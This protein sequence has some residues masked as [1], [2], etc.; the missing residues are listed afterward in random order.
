MKK[1]LFGMLQKTKKK[2]SHLLKKAQGKGKGG[3]SKGEEASSQQRQQQGGALDERTTEETEAPGAAA[4]A[5]AASTSGS[6][7]DEEWV[8]C[9]EE[10]AEGEAKVD[11]RLE[12]LLTGVGPLVREQFLNSIS[13]SEYTRKHKLMAIVGTFNVN[14]KTPEEDTRV[15]RWLLSE[16][17]VDIYVAGFQEIVPLTAS[18][19]LADNFAM[20]PALLQWET[21]LDRTL[22][23]V[24]AEESEKMFL[25]GS[26]DY[27]SFG[28][29]RQYVP[30]VA[31]SMV[32]IYLTVWVKTSLL[33][34]I[35]YKEVVSVSCGVMRVLGNKG[36]VGV[37]LRIYDTYLSFICVH[38]SSGESESD[39]ARRYWDL[40]HIFQKST[41]M[42]SSANDHDQSAM[43][44]YNILD[45]DY[46]FLFGDLNFRLNHEE[47]YIR[48]MIKSGNYMGLLD[49]DQLNQGRQ[50]NELLPGWQEG[51]ITFPPTFKYTIGTDAYVGSETNDNNSNNKHSSNGSG[52]E[53]KVQKKR[54]PAW[55]DRILWK[56]IKSVKLFGYSDVAEIRLSDH[57]PVFCGFMIHLHE[58]LEQ[59][60]EEAILSA[61]RLADLK[62]ME[63]RP[64]LELPNQFFDFGAITYDKKVTKVVTIENEGPVDAHWHLSTTGDKPD[65]L[66]VYPV[67]GKVAR[68]TSSEIKLVIHVEGGI[69]GSAGQL[70]SREID[71]ILVMTVAG[72]GDKFISITGKYQFSCFGVSPDRLSEQNPATPERLEK[73]KREYAAGARGEEEEEESAV[74][75]QDSEDTQEQQEH[76]EERVSLQLQLLSLEE[77]VKCILNVRK[78]DTAKRWFDFVPIVPLELQNLIYFI[79]NN[80]GLKKANLIISPSYPSPETIELTRG[81]MDS[82]TAIPSTKVTPVDAS[83][84][85]L[86][87]LTSF[88]EPLLPK[89][90][91]DVCSLCVP[92]GLASLDLL[93]NNMEK[94][95]YA[96]FLYLMK[97]F[98]EVLKEENSQHNG[99]TVEV[100]A[101]TLASVFL[102]YEIQAG[103]PLSAEGT[104]GYNDVI[105]RRADFLKTFLVQN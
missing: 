61:R 11:V 102:T 27:A 103:G 85:L 32:G 24:S 4:A 84:V 42:S 23:G 77:R 105:K 1:Q 39:C 31:K 33:P 28:T 48:G 15:E 104:L 45:S 67:Q 26:V 35:T 55:C 17:K 68:G 6:S 25:N 2:T 72:A 29:K 76:T 82:D 43:E 73:I 47:D 9:A 86:M 75:T 87:Y 13:S 50:R 78:E 69:S 30:L 89:Q 62:E 34:T 10:S 70:L 49:F 79:V 22:N 12:Q 5:A 101:G 91:A 21:K 41:L 83:L 99:L 52:E 44:V 54:A 53:K 90:V 14:G 46:C 98:R 66:E 96:T 65:W 16:T 64:C 97:F 36:S 100:L 88:S 92:E 71:T 93:R 58:Y 74:G 63:G 95:S 60:L 7:D 94:T 3:R 57:K 59:E 80:G 8:D 38:L 37:R 20:Q 56:A 40:G 18:N 51:E 81:A 19:V